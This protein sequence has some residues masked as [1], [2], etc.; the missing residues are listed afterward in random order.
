MMFSGRVAKECEN[1]RW[2]HAQSLCL[3]DVRDNVPRPLSSPAV[4]RFDAET[5]PIVMPKEVVTWFALTALH[6]PN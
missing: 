3:R 5:V 2:P 6:N 1:G 4:L